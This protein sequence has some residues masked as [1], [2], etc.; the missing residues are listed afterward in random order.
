MSAAM[1]DAV[2]TDR[3]DDRVMTSGKRPDKTSGCKRFASF[4]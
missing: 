4:F 2:A 1:T 3:H